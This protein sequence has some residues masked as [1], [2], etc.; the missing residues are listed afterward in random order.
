[1]LADQDARQRQQHDHRADDVPQTPAADDV[2][3]ARACVE[4]VEEA[5]AGRARAVGEVVDHALCAV[6][7]ALARR[8]AVGSGH[9]VLTPSAGAASAALR[10]LATCWIRSEE[11]TSE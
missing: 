4:A 10:S 7:V 3:R 6:L 8:R 2:D 11:H 5:V 9:R 1:D